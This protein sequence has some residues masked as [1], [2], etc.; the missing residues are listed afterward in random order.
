MRFKQQGESQV[1]LYLWGSSWY[2][3]APDSQ[4]SHTTQLFP[5]GNE[6]YGSS[7]ASDAALD[8]LFFNVVPTETTLAQLSRALDDLRRLGELDLRLNHP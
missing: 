4:L 3:T 6:F 1:Q 8:R 7:P 5:V 2:G